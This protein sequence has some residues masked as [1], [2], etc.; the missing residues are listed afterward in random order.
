VLPIF[1]WPNTVSL[2]KLVLETLCISDYRISGRAEGIELLRDCK[3]AT[4]G[5]TRRHLSEARRFG[6]LHTA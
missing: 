2:G 4:T 5:A 3:A 6:G 1:E